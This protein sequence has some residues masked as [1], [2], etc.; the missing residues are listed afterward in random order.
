ML[1][2]YTKQEDVPE[3]LREHYSKREDAK[4][5]A[6]IPDD[7][8]AVRHN[9][10]LLSE[11]TTAEGKVTQLT[12][13]LESARAGNLGRGQVVATKSD[14]ALLEEYK[15]LGAPADVKVK[16]EEHKTLSEESIQ[17]KRL[18]NLRALAKE[19]GYNEEAFIRLPKL[20]EFESRTKDGKTEWIAKIPGDNN[21]VTEKPAKEFVE[22]S[23]DIQPFMSSLKQTQGVKVHGS[24]QTTTPAQGDQFK[25]ATDFAKNYVEQSQPVA[26]PFKM[27][28]ERSSA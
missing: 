19:F 14:I 10:K 16:V 12:S 22:S 18:D 28:N 2:A 1:I 7:H 4:W 26:D 17:R 15:A 11:K 24:Q 13:D 20:P 5:H 6:D 25:W 27:F 3:A 21:T 8:P 23:A 9:A